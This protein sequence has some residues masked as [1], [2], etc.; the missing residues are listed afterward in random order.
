[1]S[2]RTAADAFSTSSQPPP[3]SQSTETVVEWVPQ[4]E[5]P[6]EREKRIKREKRQQRLQQ[7]EQQQQQHSTTDGHHPYESSHTRQPFPQD[8][9]RPHHERQQHPNNEPTP[10]P[11]TTTTATDD[12][13]KDAT[14]DKKSRNTQ[15]KTPARLKYLQKK[16]SRAKA[17]KQALPKP[18]KPANLTLNDDSSSIQTRQT[19]NQDTDDDD[20]SSEDDNNTESMTDKQRTILI[21]KALRKQTR[22]DKKQEIKRLKSLGLDKPSIEQ[23]IE[24]WSQQ[25]RLEQ[26]AVEAKAIHDRV[27]T[28]PLPR[29]PR[30][31]PPATPSAT[32]TE[33]TQPSTTQPLNDNHHNN[34]DDDKQAKQAKLERKQLKRQKRQ[35]RHSLAI[36]QELQKV[37]QETYGTRPDE[38]D[39]VND[40]D[41]DN[42]DNLKPDESQHGDQTHNDTNDEPPAALMRLPDATRPVLPTQQQLRRL[43]VHE[44]VKQKVTVDPELLINIQDKQLGLSDRSIKRLKDMDIQN[45]FAVQTATFPFLLLQS[46]RTIY[47]PFEPIRDLCVSAPT[48][49]GKTLSYV[50]PIVEILSQKI[51]TRLRALI[52]LPTRD[53]VTQVRETFEKFSKST[54]IKIGVTTGQHSF[55]HEQEMLM[56]QIRDN[57]NSNEV[58]MSMNSNSIDI[59]IATPGRLIDH[60][61]LTKGFNLQHLRFLII[62][63]AD[64][65]MNQSFNDWLPLILN[66]LKPKPLSLM[67]NVD[68][69]SQ[70]EAMAPDWL[71]AMKQEP[72]SDVDERPHSRDSAKIDALQLNK[73]IYISVED[74]F[75]ST[76]QQDQNQTVTNGSIDEETKFTLPSQLEEHVIISTSTLK[77]LYLLHLIRHLKLTSILCFT[78]SVEASTRLVKLIELFQQQQQRQHDQFKNQKD[79]TIVV[80]SYSSELNMNERRTLLQDF[81]NQKITMLICSDLIARG[82]DLPQVSNV[83][84]YDIPSDMRKYVHRVGRTARAGR[85]GVAWS[86]VEEQEVAPF[87]SIMK[88]SQH[89]SKLNKYKIKD[90]EIEPLLSGYNIALTQLKHFL[91]ND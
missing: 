9:P 68:G 38:H 79:E 36:E 20:D 45:A 87:K 13:N 11:V 26:R 32:T 5:D 19:T 76:L 29:P 40:N 41:N 65:L 42:D 23:A 80:K 18:N 46:P 10:A 47:A 61:R 90:K 52:L 57:N 39:N 69:I 53:L 59:L 8:H 21:K 35:Q 83:I 67:M 70:H 58:S 71:D 7:L 14:R 60:L 33:T 86:L 43:Q 16:K 62:D 37:Q 89:W 73:P 75:D 85:K 17:K 82:I 88:Q 64:R 27:T 30:P 63:E 1:M 6:A 55:L 51:V 91:S 77:P 22:D 50:V 15:S 34:D 12:T 3:P 54:G 66:E 81:K 74:E 44:S 84:S 24:L 4:G 25:R 72:L 49:S 48:G 31:P 78:K 56:G 2:K 28:T